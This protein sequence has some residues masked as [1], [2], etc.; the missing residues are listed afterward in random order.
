MSLFVFNGKDIKSINVCL[1]SFQ[2]ANFFYFSPHPYWL[3]MTR[4]FLLCIHFF[5]LLLFNFNECEDEMKKKKYKEQTSRM[6][7]W[8]R[9][10]T[11]SLEK[12]LITKVCFKMTFCLW[13][14][15]NENCFARIHFWSWVGRL[16]I[17]M[18]LLI[19]F[20]LCRK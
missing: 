2:V 3:T 19:A 9:N 18:I 6:L 17:W 5:F 4:W 8:M 10:D 1:Y 14:L 12:M 11:L 13:I 7:S 20:V 15:R 16:Y